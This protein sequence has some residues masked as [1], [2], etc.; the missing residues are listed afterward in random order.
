M[1]VNI[2]KR[3]GQVLCPFM[4]LIVKNMEYKLAI[5]MDGKK[6][7]DAQF[8]TKAYDQKYARDWNVQ[9]HMN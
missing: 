6:H 4:L 3:T 9:E 1:S 2:K 7:Y 5:Q 8:V